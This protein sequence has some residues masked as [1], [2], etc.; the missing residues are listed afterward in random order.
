MKHTVEIEVSA[1]EQTW[2]EKA[3]EIIGMTAGALVQ[4]IAET[5]YQVFMEQAADRTVRKAAPHKP[6]PIDWHKRDKPAPINWRGGA[7]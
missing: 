6:A 1:P 4:T 5:G 2:L 7:Q 3:A